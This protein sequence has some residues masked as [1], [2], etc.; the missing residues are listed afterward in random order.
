MFVL[1]PGMMGGCSGVRGEGV[2]YLGFGGGEQV[3]LEG[4]GGRKLMQKRAV[5]FVSFL[6]EIV[7]LDWVANRLWE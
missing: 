3:I 6:S 7:G 5:D 1:N 4:E 2:S